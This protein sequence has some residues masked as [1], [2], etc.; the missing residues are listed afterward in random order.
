MNT[1]PRTPKPSIPQ[2]DEGF[3]LS[4]AAKKDKYAE[5]RRRWREKNVE[6]RKLD[7]AAWRNKNPDK[8]AIHAR[9]YYHNNKNKLL[10]YTRN[11]RILY[12]E[13]HSARYK[14]QYAIRKGYIT[15]PT[16]C[17]RNPDHA[18]RK[19]EAHH[20]DYSKPLEVI[21]VCRQCH[22]VLDGVTKHNLNPAP[23]E[24]SQ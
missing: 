5:C 21:W 14:L 23:G 10:N 24:V 11:D 3:S 16:V 18:G 12:P 4:D 1:D 22:R 8:A 6:K 7:M 20:P 15:K 2:D 9:T 17:S 19:V 13:K